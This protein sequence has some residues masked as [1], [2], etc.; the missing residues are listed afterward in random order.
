MQYLPCLNHYFNTFLITNSPTNFQNNGIS[1]TLSPLISYTISQFLFLLPSHK[2]FHKKL[3][4]ESALLDLSDQNL[5]YLDTVA[6]P[7]GMMFY[8]MTMQTTH[9]KCFATHDQ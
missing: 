2:H 4:K 7:E 6:F 8:H 3:Q 9:S 1:S 5:L